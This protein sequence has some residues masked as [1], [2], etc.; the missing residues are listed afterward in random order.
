MS[1]LAFALLRFCD[2]Q[3]GL[4][5]SLSLFLSFPFVSFAGVYFAFGSMLGFLYDLIPFFFCCLPFLPF[6]A[7]PLKK[8]LALFQFHP[9]L[10][11]PLLLPFFFLYF[12]PIHELFRPLFSFLHFSL[13]IIVFFI[14]YRRHFS[15]FYPTA[16]SKR[17]HA[18]ISSSSTL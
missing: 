1:S 13:H 8:H 14:P 4:A 15:L 16:R 18:F 3:C 2:A 6:L 12:R 11:L 10:H 7:P 9:L 17:M 5:F